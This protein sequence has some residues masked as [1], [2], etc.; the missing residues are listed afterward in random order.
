MRRVYQAMI[1]GIRNSLMSSPLVANS[2]ASVPDVCV[3]DVQWAVGV[4][5]GSKTINKI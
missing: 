5:I 2:N 3:P 4:T 1:I